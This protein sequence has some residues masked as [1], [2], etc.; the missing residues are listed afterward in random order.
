[1]PSLC[2][3]KGQL[4]SAGPSLGR[5]ASVT[6]NG[7]KFCHIGPRL[8]SG[9]GQN[10]LRNAGTAVLGW[11]GQAFLGGAPE[12]RGGT[13]AIIEDRIAY[14]APARPVQPGRRLPFRKG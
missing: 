12:R 9:E 7:G 5:A 6:E 1:M 11:L 2:A 8:R 13:N 3:A 10:Q 14:I 4:D